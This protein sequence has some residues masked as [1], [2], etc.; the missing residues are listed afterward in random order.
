MNISLPAAL[1]GQLRNNEIREAL[2]ATHNFT[3]AREIQRETR[4]RLGNQSIEGIA[5]SDALR[6]YLEIQQMP[7]ERQQV[8]LEYGKKL[9][10]GQE[11]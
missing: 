1:E 2:K 3:I 9:I 8:L 11:P 5:P 4:L 6:K 7:P 10:E